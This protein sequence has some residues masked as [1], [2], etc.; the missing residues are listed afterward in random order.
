VQ[1]YIIEKVANHLSKELDIDVHI[2]QFYYQPLSDLTIDDIYI[3]DQQKD[4]L[5][6]LEQIYINFDPLQLKDYLLDIEQVFVKEPYI[7]L[8][9]LSDKTLNCQFLL[10][11]FQRDSTVFPLKVS[12]NQ[13]LLEQTRIRYNEVLVDQLDLAL[14][15]P[16]LSKDS[17]DFYVNSMHLRAKTDKINA[18]F[19]ADIHGKLDSIYAENM[20]LTYKHK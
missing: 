12:I 20:V 6:Y 16:I 18:T 19:E 4:T 11:A 8:Y 17:L 15:M 3:S 14:T 1:T 2:G 13:L 9:T 5:A 10:D 7:N